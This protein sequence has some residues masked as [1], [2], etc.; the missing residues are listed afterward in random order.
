VTQAAG[1]LTLDTSLLSLH[2]YRKIIQDEKSSFVGHINT[3]LCI[4]GLGKTSE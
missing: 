1:D 3:L 2:Q 4:P